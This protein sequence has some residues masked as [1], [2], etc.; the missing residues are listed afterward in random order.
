M[1]HCQLCNKLSEPNKAANKIVIEKREKQYT[2]RLKKGLKEVTKESHGWEIV[3]EK[4][5]C[6][7]CAN[8]HEN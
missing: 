7:S 4:L 5:V 1:Y 6:S 3:S 8:P 2:N